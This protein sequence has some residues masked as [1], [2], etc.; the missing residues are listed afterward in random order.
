VIGEPLLLTFH[1]GQNLNDW[2]P[3]EGLNFYG[4]QKETGA[5]RE[6]VTF[7][8]QWLHWI[9][10]RVASVQGYY[11]ALQGLPNDVDD[12]FLT[13]A[14]F[15]SGLVANVTVEVISRPAIR[16]G[17]LLSARGTI[18]FDIIAGTLRVFTEESQQWQTVM[19]LENFNTELIYVD[20]IRTFLA[21]TRGETE[22]PLTYE[23]DVH[24]EQILLACERSH[25]EGRSVACSEF[26]EA[27]APRAAS[28]SA[29]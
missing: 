5:G 3:W 26:D 13:I 21:A 22:W 11:G 29:Q 9:F 1:L 24:F 18:A 14:R 28:V 10:G 6:M 15:E 17:R 4:G 8:Y 25:E 20:E 27:H 12:A 16:A 23:E 7:D 19:A 2:H